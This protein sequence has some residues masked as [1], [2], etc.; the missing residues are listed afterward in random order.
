MDTSAAD[1]IAQC[2]I[3]QYNRLPKKG[4]PATK[5]PGKDEWT[6]LA[7]IVFETRNASKY[8]CVALGTGLK[9]LHM[10]QLSKFGDS[11]HDSHAEVIAR[12]ALVVYLAEQLLLCKQDKDSIFESQDGRFKVKESLGLKVH[13]YTSQSP[14]GDATVEHLQTAQ[15][16]AEDS[17]PS[18]K[19]RKVG[20]GSVI[21][22][23]QKFTDTGSLRLK[24]GRAD[25][26][27]TTSMSCS[28]KIARWNVLGLQGALLATLIPPMYLASV[29]VGE[30]F[31]ES[32][33]D[34]ALN[35]RV[36]GVTGLPEAYRA[37]TCQV[38]HTTVDFARGQAV[39]KSLAAEAI[40]ADASV[41]WYRGAKASA[42]LVNG[43]RQG[44]KAKKGVCQPAN[45]WP[46]ICKAAIFRKLSP[47][48]LGDE[49]AVS[50]RQ[51]KDRAVD[52]TAAKACL[53]SKPPFTAWVK[54]P[55]GHEAFDV[56]GTLL[57]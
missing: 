34:R 2:V 31:T 14:C 36:A 55:D 15:D 10:Q 1:Q 22:G 53:L 11:V 44:A 52:Y 23:H 5:A 17:E 26:I 54:C 13:L 40:T 27:P 7:G 49:E 32:S 38:R 18:A 33:V 57:V 37:N 6:V 9:C 45:L 47:L 8:E 24:P 21:R 4:K 29:V 25:S 16:K 3:D 35:R 46:D 41:C 20:D 56:T 12:R 28:D 39:M 43:R 30:L 19:R 42:A 50:Y 48:V 51:A